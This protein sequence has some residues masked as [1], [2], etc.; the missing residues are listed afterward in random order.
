MKTEQHV[1][2]LLAKGNSKQTAWI[3]QEHAIKD[4]ALRL[5]TSG[6]W[7]DGWTVRLVG[8]KMSSEKIQRQSDRIHK[9]IFGSIK[10][11]ISIPA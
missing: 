3:P 4:K 9:G 10:E 2:C 6:V 5:K 1:Q 7:E 11:R 8:S